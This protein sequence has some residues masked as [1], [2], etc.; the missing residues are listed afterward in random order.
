VQIVSYS[1]DVS[2]L[3]LFNTMHYATI[4]S[5]VSCGG[6]HALGAVCVLVGIF[7]FGSHKHVA[8]NKHLG[9]KFHI[10]ATT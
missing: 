10:F 7:P 9:E 3:V 4:G 2:K 8:T 5:V 6:I 1:A